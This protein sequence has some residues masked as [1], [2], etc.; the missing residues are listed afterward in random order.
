MESRIIYTYPLRHG[1]NEVE[2]PAD[3][4]ALHVGSQEGQTM[5]WASR[6]EFALDPRTVRVWVVGT[7]SPFDGAK[8]T[9][10]LGTVL[11]SCGYFVWHVYTDDAEL[12]G[13]LTLSSRRPE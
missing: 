2:L 5:L 6:P 1:L 10:Y 4:R 8:L 3:A 11:S 13:E 9:H 7:G 12:A